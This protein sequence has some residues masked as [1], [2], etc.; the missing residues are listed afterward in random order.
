ML[1]GKLLVGSAE[2]LPQPD[3]ST[4][5]LRSA[6]NIKYRIG[7][8]FCLNLIHT[9]FNRPRILRVGK[10]EFLAVFCLE[11]IDIDIGTIVCIAALYLQT[12]ILVRHRTDIVIS[13]SGILNIPMLIASIEPVIL[14]QVRACGSSSLCIDALAGT[15]SHNRILTTRAVND[16]K[17]LCAA[18]CLFIQTDIGSV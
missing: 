11:L 5:R 3:V 17:I 13:V 2:V 1:Y 9:I 6:G 10:A 8:G 15:H 4:I 18:L 16:L 7:I 12:E 14:D